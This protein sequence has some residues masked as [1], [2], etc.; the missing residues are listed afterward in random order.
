MNQ[1]QP[2]NDQ[3]KSSL[4][5]R[6][7]PALCMDLEIARETL[8]RI[9]MESIQRGHWLLSVGLTKEVQGIMEKEGP[10]KSF[11]LLFRLTRKEGGHN[12]TKNN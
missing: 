8:R 11:G 1:K 2:Q 12:H 4:H 10:E 6:L 3:T 9:E 7:W 5:Y